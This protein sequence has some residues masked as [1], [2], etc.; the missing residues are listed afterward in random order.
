MVYRGDLF[1]TMLTQAQAKNLT[2]EQQMVYTLMMAS[3]SML[4]DMPVNK[5]AL[6]VGLQI[7]SLF[8]QGI[9]KDMHLDQDGVVSFIFN[10]PLTDP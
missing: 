8:A 10:T 1:K 3:P 7:K 4:P 2:F 9:L 6:E 5:E